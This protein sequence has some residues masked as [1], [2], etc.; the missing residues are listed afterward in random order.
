MG[1]AVSTSSS[2]Q[3]YVSVWPYG[4]VRSLA[5]SGNIQGNLDGSFTLLPMILYSRQSGFVA[6]YGEV[7]GIYYVPGSGVTSLTSE[8][9]ITIGA[10]TYLVVQNVDKVS[11]NDYA[12]LL[13]K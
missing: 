1:P 4:T 6:E 10:D 8:D 13:L 5:E 2:G 9:T 3:V 12:A 7:H 11:R